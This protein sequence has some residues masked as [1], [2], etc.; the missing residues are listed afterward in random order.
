MINTQPQPRP[1]A[2]T[3][4]PQPKQST[5]P[6]HYKITPNNHGP[7]PDPITNHPNNQRH[8]PRH[9]RRLGPIGPPDRVESEHEEESERDEPRA[10]KKASAMSHGIESLKAENTT[11]NVSV[12][13]STEAPRSSRITAPRET[14]SGRQRDRLRFERRGLGFEGEEKE[15]ESE[16]EEK[17]KNEGRGERK[18]I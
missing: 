4:P 15:P 16:R 12:L 11:A 13:V 10:K 14:G 6:T 7:T 18:R 3:A 17:R 1:H 5:T 2:A 9:D 8:Q